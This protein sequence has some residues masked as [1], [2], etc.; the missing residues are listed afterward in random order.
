MFEFSI[1]SLRLESEPWRKIKTGSFPGDSECML[2][3]LQGIDIA[4]CSQ[5]DK[6]LL[7][8]SLYAWPDKAAAQ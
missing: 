6:L 5:L 7:L 1:K 8:A 3:H 2:Y 4:L